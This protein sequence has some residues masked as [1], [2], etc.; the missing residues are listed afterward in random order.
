MHILVT[1]TPGSGKTTLVKYATQVFDKRFYDADELNGLCH[2]RE[3]KTGQILGSVGQFSATGDNWYQKY[4]W[5]WHEAILRNFL[6]Q[7]PGCFVCGSA[8]NIADCYRLFDH[9]IILRKNPRR[10]RS[11]PQQS[12]PSQPIWQ[13]HQTK[14]R[15]YGLAK[16]L[17]PR[18]STISA[19]HYRGEQDRRPLCPN[20]HDSNHKTIL[21]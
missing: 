20:L 2:W 6:R 15:L 4:G 11:Q 16:L 19:H 21:S 14:A 7:H 9:I 18:D 17:N 1:G 8:E 3:I 12:R 5:Y 10:A 13:N